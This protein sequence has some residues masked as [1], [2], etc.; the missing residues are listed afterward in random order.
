VIASKNTTIHQGDQVDAGTLWAP[1]VN[2]T[3]KVTSQGVG[4]GL[5]Y[6]L[7]RNFSI[8]G[9]YNWAVYSANESG[10]FRAGF[11]TPKNRYS[12]GISNR[13][14]TKNIGF[15]VNFRYQDMFHWVS[16]YGEWDVPRYGV[17]DAQLSYKIAP[18]K[19]LIKLGG[20]NIGGGDYRNSLGGPFV[21][22]QYY[23][24]VT[25]DEFLK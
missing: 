1:S 13:K 9:N 22:Q 21:G 6:N 3:E 15:N 12:V 8:N 14:V 19:T 24:S 17:L 2:A 7:P 5:T 18:I 23:V 25:F 11:N 20:T 4:V 10:D 16:S